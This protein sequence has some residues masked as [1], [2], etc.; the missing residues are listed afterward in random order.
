MILQ[1]HLI[2]N[3]QNKLHF[4][5]IW[6]KGEDIGL[7]HGSNIPPTKVDIVKPDNLNH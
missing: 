5:V 1:N 6:N 3:A 2:V 7:P 4:G